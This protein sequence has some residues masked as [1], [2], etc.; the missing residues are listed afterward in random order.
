VA[1]S[2]VDGRHVPGNRQIPQNSY[3]TAKRRARQAVNWRHLGCIE[4]APL[5][6]VRAARTMFAALFGELALHPRSDALAEFSQDA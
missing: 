2:P 5:P 6:G 3:R 4:P 1:L